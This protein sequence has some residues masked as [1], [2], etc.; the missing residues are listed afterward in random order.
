MK[1]FQ[2]KEM[3]LAQLKWA[4]LAIAIITVLIIAD[5]LPH[6]SL[7]VGLIQ[8]TLA[9]V[10]KMTVTKRAAATEDVTSTQ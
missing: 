6:P 3:S 10:Q 1:N 8:R 4:R 7:S 2:A 5:L 9:Q